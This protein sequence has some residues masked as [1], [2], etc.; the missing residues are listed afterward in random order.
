MKQASISTLM[1]RMVDRVNVKSLEIHLTSGSQTK[2]DSLHITRELNFL[3]WY[4]LTLIA[5][6]EG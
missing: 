5:S 3:K 1:Q 4:F 6:I 2:V